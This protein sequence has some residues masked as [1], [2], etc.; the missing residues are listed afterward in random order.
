[1]NI[2]RQENLYAYIWCTIDKFIH[3]SSN[4][5]LNLK[6]GTNII[7]YSRCLYSVK[8]IM[9]CIFRIQLAVDKFS[10]YLSMKYKL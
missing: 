2:L 10:L 9:K 8:L 4:V 7:I 6:L 3:N 1:M 5:S